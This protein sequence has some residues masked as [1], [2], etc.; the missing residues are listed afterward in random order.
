MQVAYATF[1]LRISISNLRLHYLAHSV[2]IKFQCQ[3][4]EQNQN[5][6]ISGGQLTILE[7]LYH[8]SVKIRYHLMLLTLLFL[9]TLFS[10]ALFTCQIC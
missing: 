7:R 2:D 10:E 4:Y 8:L 1:D 9:F 3:S 5:L 6:W